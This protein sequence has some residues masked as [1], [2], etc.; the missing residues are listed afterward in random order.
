MSSAA[1]TADAP[2]TFTRRQIAVIM[3][4]LMLGM[5]L[6]A[7]DQM[8]LGPAIPKI[9]SDLPGA[10]EISWIVAAYLLTTTAVTPIYGK[11]SDLYG[12]GALFQVGISIFVIASALC[13]LSTS[14]EML[15]A[16]RALQGVGGGGLI[17]LAQATVA[18]VV[19]PRERGRYQAYFATVWILASGL[20]PIFGGVFAD[21]LS[22]RWVFWINV[23]LGIV[24]LLVSR[25]TLKALIR[26][27]VRHKIDYLGA[28]LLVT[29]TCCLLLVT[30]MVGNGMAWDAPVILELMGAAVVLFGLA[31]VQERRAVEPILPPRLFHNQSYVLGNITSATYSAT[32]LG[33]I[34][35]VP[36][37][38]QM[39][40]GFGASESGFISAPMFLA[41]PI[42]NVIGG[43]ITAAT[44][45]Y[46]I[47]PVVG[48]ALSTVMLALMAFCTPS[49][50][51]VIP[52]I[53]STLCGVGIGLVGPIL[54]LGIQNAVDP[55]D[56]GSATGSFAFFRN[57]G[58]SFGV[59]LFGTILI[60][61]MD[62]ALRTLPGP[63][64]IDSGAALLNAGADAL[65]QMPEA[66][67]TTVAEGISTAYSIMFISGAIGT[68]IAFLSVL[69]MREL[70]LKTVTGVAER[71]A[72]DKAD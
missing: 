62:R 60:S 71:A 35:F 50:P 28:I 49:T 39:V 32:M 25:T 19:S 37:F 30:T 15:V 29:A 10:L 18:D 70:P 52:M 24:A 47:F 43:Q 64:G 1:V 72:A 21:Y 55:R 6:A 7:F 4:G 48:L 12:R 31:V 41:M 26:K 16:S 9:S 46:K 8:I 54:L 2:V 33:A 51:L 65:R 38:F 53:E 5:S 59:T 68:G 57:L 44:G 63:V 36:T 45:R 23:P 42:S 69:F 67:R 13:A 40:Y 17:M 58:G 3:V 11:L 66:L 34:T 14:I 22:W 56:I 20:G 27:G 61:C